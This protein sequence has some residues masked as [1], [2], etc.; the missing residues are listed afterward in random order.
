MR[1]RLKL[2]VILRWRHWRDEILQKWERELN[3]EA[4][5]RREI[6]EVEVS[7][8]GFERTT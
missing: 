2:R 8:A 7:R 4:L 5:G 1:G 3:W 6:P